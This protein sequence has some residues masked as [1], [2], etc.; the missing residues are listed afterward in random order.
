M[1]RNVSMPRVEMSMD[2]DGGMSFSGGD[3]PRPSPS[4]VQV[5]RSIPV[6][7]PVPVPTPAPVPSPAPVPASPV[8]VP[9]ASESTANVCTSVGSR[10]LEVN[11]M[12]PSADLLPPCREWHEKDV[13]GWTQSDGVELVPRNGEELSSLERTVI[14][15]DVEVS[16]D[17]ELNLED[18][19][20]AG[21]VSDGDILRDPRQ[22]LVFLRQGGEVRRVWIM[23]EGFRSTLHM[24]TG[25]SNR[26]PEDVIE[27]LLGSGWLEDAPGNRLVL[28][29]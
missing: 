1:G 25:R 16:D 20:Y 10:P 28:K 6:S 5:S 8:P 23:G 14:L 27:S 15:D 21:G 4:S 18:T 24:E 7:S 11:D 17:L 22:V 29:G 2:S 19:L 13:S 26:I 12:I 9:P 3:R